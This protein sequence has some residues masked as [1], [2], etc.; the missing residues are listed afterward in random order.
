MPEPPTPNSQHYDL[1]ELD[2]KFTRRA[3]DITRY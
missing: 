2:K 3:N 1:P